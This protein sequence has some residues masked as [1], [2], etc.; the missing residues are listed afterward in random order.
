MKGPWLVKLPGEFIQNSLQIHVPLCVLP[1]REE[2]G[3]TV[4]VTASALLPLRGQQAEAPGDTATAT[5]SSGSLG[6]S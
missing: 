2:G 5:A 4:A 3:L 1:S 6:S